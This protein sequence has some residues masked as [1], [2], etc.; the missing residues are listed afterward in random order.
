M[1]ARPALV[2]LLVT[3]CGFRASTGVGAGSSEVDS[4]TTAAP[5]GFCVGDAII[6][7]CLAEPPAL[8]LTIDRAT[9]VDTDGGEPCATNATASS[10]QYCILAGSAITIMGGQTLSAHGS[11]PLVLL[12]SGTITVFGMIDVAGH[13][14]NQP[15]TSG[16]GVVGCAG[17][18][19]ATAGGGGHG[20]TFGSSG[21]NGGADND[22]HLGGVAATPV[23]QTTLR[24]GCA[25][26]A[27]LGAGSGAA[28]PAGGGVALMSATGIHITGV[29]DASGG[30]GGGAMPNG[31]GGGGGGAGGMIVLDAPS[32]D[33]A[34]TAKIFAN[35]GSGGE[36]S[37]GLKGVDGNDA[38]LDPNVAAVGGSGQSSGGDGGAGARNDAMAG[39][40][41]NAGGGGGGGGVGVIRLFKATSLGGV[42]SPPPR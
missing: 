16:P 22:G 15:Q 37:G 18:T 13:L 26:E 35:G 17:G 23:D 24:G 28:G 38:P 39:N 8:P 3:G 30:G 9:K 14:A 41:S 7:A 1:L 5:G 36:G 6:T 2:M 29:I 40:A 19:P 42:V 11:R 20:G 33:V 31:H 25:G 34:G 10:S 21:G 32:V 27:G 12:S 4:G